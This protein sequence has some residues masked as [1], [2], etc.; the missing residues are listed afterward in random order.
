[1]ARRRNPDD[2]LGARGYNARVLWPRYTPGGGVNSG[3]EPPI[4]PSNTLQSNQSNLILTAN[5]RDSAAYARR[6]SRN[7]SSGYSDYVELRPVSGRTNP[8]TDGKIAVTTKAGETKYVTQAQYD[9]FY[10]K[11]DS[12]PGSATGSTPTQKKQTPFQRALA[13]AISR[14]KRNPYAPEE[15]LLRE[16]EAQLGRRA[17]E[18][19]RE[20]QRDE[21]LAILEGFARMGR[22]APLQRYSA[23]TAKK[24]QE[25]MQAQLEGIYSLEAKWEK[26][27]KEARAR[28]ERR[29]RAPLDAEW[30]GHGRPHGLGGP[31]RPTANT[32]KIKVRTSD[33][34]FR[35]VTPEEYDLMSGRDPRTRNNPKREIGDSMQARRK[36]KSCS[37]ALINPGDSIT[38]TALGW[39]RTD[40]L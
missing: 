1:M 9:A 6:N 26:E 37:G 5:P 11:S 29:T 40:L 13:Y 22:R 20:V 27:E 36:S 21:S 25:A 14:G 23:R 19:D 18:R 3:S 8:S 35:H 39:E 34:K 10:A 7:G 38:K 2:I 31:P 15:E 30:Y 16:H 33:G 12:A 17:A 28:Q 32:Q 4:R 24:M